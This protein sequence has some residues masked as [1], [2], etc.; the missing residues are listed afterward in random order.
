M[1]HISTLMSRTQNPQKS[2]LTQHGLSFLVEYNGIRILFDAGSDGDFLR[3]AEKMNID[4]S[5]LSAAVLSHGHYDHAAG[6]RDLMKAGLAPRYLFVGDGFFE[7]RYM[8]RNIRYVNMSSNLTED[9]IRSNGIEI[10]TLKDNL[11]YAE[12]IYIVKGFRQSNPYEKIPSE[13]IILRDN[14]FVQDEFTD[15]LCLVLDT[16]KGL[17]IITGSSHMGLCNLL[18]RVHE[19]FKKPIYAIIGGFPVDPKDDMRAKFTMHTL[20]EY[21]VKHISYCP[22][23]PMPSDTFKFSTV[24]INIVSVGDEFFLM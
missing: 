18:D 17:V 21:N 4:L 15:E 2:L 5:G 20:R 6:Y 7:N 14:G 23:N 12:G 9:E 11:H 16:P 22:A 19:V 13:Y 8:K 3:N 1:L 10:R 24:D